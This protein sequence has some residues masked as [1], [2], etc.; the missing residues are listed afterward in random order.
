LGGFRFERV[1]TNEPGRLRVQEYRDE[2]GKTAW[3]VWSPTGEERH[4]TATLERTPGKLV[5]AERMPFIAGER[6]VKA[7][8]AQK[9]DGGV[10][11]EV[12]ESPLYLI[13]ER[14]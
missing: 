6:P 8:A 9:A 7:P 2:A 4:F 12:D 13:F 11:A 14:R 3:A 5:A 10:E 1:V